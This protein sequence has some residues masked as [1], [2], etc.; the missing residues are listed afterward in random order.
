[1]NH[2]QKLQALAA[3]LY[4][5]G[6]KSAEWKPKAGDYYTLTRCDLELFRVLEYDEESDQA[7]YT[8][9]A[10]GGDPQAIEDA[11]PFTDFTTGG[12]HDCRVPVADYLAKSWGLPMNL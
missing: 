8:R 1:M 6:T 11:H 7:R 2:E 3:H 4:P 10:H 9:V 5:V 12:F